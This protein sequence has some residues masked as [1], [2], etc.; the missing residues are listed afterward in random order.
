[1]L[2]LSRP[3][4]CSSPLPR[5]TIAPSPKDRATSASACALT[6]AAR[7]F[8]S[9]PSGISRNASNAISVTTNPRTESPRN[10]SRSLVASTPCSNAYER[11]V[12]AV[13]RSSSSRNLMPS[14]SSSASGPVIEEA[15]ARLTP[16]LDL[17]GLPAGVETAVP[18]DTMRKLRLVTLRAFRVRRRLRLPVGRAFAPPGL[19][20]LL[21]RDR[22]VSSLLVF[23]LVF[24]LVFLPVS[25][26]VLA[27]GQVQLL[28]QRREPVP[29]RV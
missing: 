24:R 27:H 11:C 13:S 25:L 12:R 7:S 28:E 22:H 29:A 26:G 18:A 16:S 10:S 5:R 23:R 21:L 3:P 17:D 4:L 14:A 19:G 9:S 8:A 15:S 1:M 20:L 6:I 2:P